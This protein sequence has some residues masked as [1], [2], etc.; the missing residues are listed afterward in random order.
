MIREV[1]DRQSPYAQALRRGHGADRQNEFI[2]SWQAL[3]AAALERIA[4]G[5]DT[6]AGPAAAS[7]RVEKV[8]TAILAAL[9]GGATLSWLA[10]DAQ[11]LE[12]ALDIALA[13]VL[14][15]PEPEDPDDRRPD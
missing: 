8:A 1:M 4:A 3:I 15:H 14:L 12:A 6:G 7:G 11:S 2:Q 13:P 9:H 10:Q 5:C